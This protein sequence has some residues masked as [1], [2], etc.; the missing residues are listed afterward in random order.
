MLSAQTSLQKSA[1]GSS[2]PRPVQAWALP[3]KRRRHAYKR[4]TYRNGT[5]LE[6]PGNSR[7]Q[8]ID[9]N[10]ITEA[11]LSESELLQ[12]VNYLDEDGLLAFPGIGPYLAEAIIA[13]RI[14]VDYY[15]EL[16]DLLEVP[17]FG[18]KRFANLVGRQPQHT[19]LKLRQLLRIDS[20]AVAPIS[21]EDF[22]P[23]SR[24]ASGIRELW[25]LDK[26]EFHSSKRTLESKGHLIVE[27]IGSFRLI[28]VCDSESLKGRSNYI[29][30][31]LPKIIR[32]INYE[33]SFTTTH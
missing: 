3:Q 28:F 32:S 6:E 30:R 16:E 27:R 26:S 2:R 15:T 21:T 17:K 1:I 33:R 23:W 8:T 22:R 9:S 5:V 12:A 7:L 4:W 19:K 10:S 20:A 13:H 29:I 24:P 18:V 25:L 14:L 31:K 11:G